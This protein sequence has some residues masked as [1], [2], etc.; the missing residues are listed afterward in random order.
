MLC[1]VDNPTIY[2]GETARN[3]YTRAKEHLDTYRYRVRG[4]KKESFIL[5]H[6]VEKHDCREPNFTAKVT[7]T[8]TDCLTR[9]VSESIFIRRT[10]EDILN[11]KS[12]WHQPSLFR[13]QQEVTQG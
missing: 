6:Q 12:E 3:L 2:V 4:G 8:F 10:E 7:K 11:S 5:K 1:P 13:V 9:Q